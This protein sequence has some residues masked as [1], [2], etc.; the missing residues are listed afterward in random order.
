MQGDVSLFIQSLRYGETE[1]GMLEFDNVARPLVEMTELNSDADRD[2]LL[3]G[4]PL[5]ASG[6]TCIGC[7]I[8]LAL[9]V[10]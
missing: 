1:I 3:D 4:I 9:E 5:E 8:L 7:G 6:G 10:G 2:K